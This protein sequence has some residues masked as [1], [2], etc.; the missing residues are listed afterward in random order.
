M[1]SVLVCGLCPLPFENTLRSFG[2]GIRSWQ[3]A[4]SLASSGHRVH[5]V[6]LKIASGYEDTD[7]LRRETRDGVT[8]ERLDDAEFFDTAALARRIEEV[9]PE[10]LVGA[11]V[12]GS[13]VLA[14]C[15]AELPFWADQ[16]GHVMA[17]AQAKAH[18]EGENW[19]LAHFWQ[20]L[21]PVLA[22]ADKLSVVSGRQRWAA[23]G[24][25][26][27]AGR[28]S[29]ETCGY[30]L[31][32]VIP[33]AVVPPRPV[34]TQPVL[35]GRQIPEDAFV[36]LWSG[37][38]NVW[39]DVHTLFEGL[40]HAM[41]DND[42]VCFVSTGGEIG[43]HDETTYRGFER[44]VAGSRFRRRFHLQGW[45]RAEL[46]PSYQAEADLGVLTETPIYEGRL[47]SKNRIV[48]WL[49]AGLPVA[50]NRVGDLGALLAGEELGLTFEVGDAAGLARQ[51]LWAADHPEDLERL[52][53]RAQGYAAR[54]LSFEATTRDL[55]SW[56]RRPCRAPDA[57][58]RH[59]VRSPRDFAPA[60]PALPA[61]PAADPAPVDVTA[62]EAAARGDAGGG[63]VH[64]LRRRLLG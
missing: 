24:E 32:A 45:V 17:E 42:R 2:P 40:E 61:A 62:L 6:A 16:F 49:G 25:L 50:Y 63:F 58:L 35:R 29:A 9:R 15:G 7:A 13:H 11:T 39:S 3:L 37:G 20:L 33:C 27:M 22:T 56:A 46:V 28:L 8:I 54:E 4:H 43:G 14:R 52:R 21:E 64:R 53:R 12:Y 38:Y 44:R 41:A 1:T 36:V 57:G 60:A 30:E 23:V 47:G 10:A 34:S 18:L 55:V 48:Q 19:P 31:T 26:G 5:L 59:G 51:I